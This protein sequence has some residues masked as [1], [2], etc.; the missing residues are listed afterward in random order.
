MH[1]SLL[2]MP[3]G[4]NSRETQWLPI[5]EK[6]ELTWCVTIKPHKDKIEGPLNLNVSLKIEVDSLFFLLYSPRMLMVLIE[7]P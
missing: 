2:R 4:Y 3:A 7:L 6:K 1:A 5:D